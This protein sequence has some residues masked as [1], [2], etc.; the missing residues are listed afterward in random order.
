MDIN[1]YI[2]KQ[3]RLRRRFLKLTQTKL[4]EEID[5]TFQQIQK[6]EKGQNKIS[7]SKLFELARKMT[8]PVGYFFDEFVD[9]NSA[10]N[11][12]SIIGE[13]A[14]EF[15]YGNSEEINLI[16]AYNSIKNKK[17]RKKLLMFLKA[18]TQ[19]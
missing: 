18:L 19:D 8:V 10:N 1:L 9:L 14:L 6:Y 2:G 11:T 13:E 3:I 4:G 7:A 16:E 5:V 15:E 12:P 17:T